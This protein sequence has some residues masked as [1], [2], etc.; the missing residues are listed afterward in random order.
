MIVS[1]PHIPSQLVGLS[2]HEVRAFAGHPGLSIAS[3]RG[4]IWITQDGDPRD[5]V[6]DAGESHALDRD[7]PVYLQA[8]DAAWVTMPATLEAPP[9][10]E[11]GLWA[12]LSRAAFS[13]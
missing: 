11:P 9:T 8:L 12:R 4:R 5:V 6:I 7:G 3:H 1:T 13:A 2:R 10:R